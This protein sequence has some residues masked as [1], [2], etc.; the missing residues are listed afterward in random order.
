MSAIHTSAAEMIIMMRRYVYDM[1]DLTYDAL[2]VRPKALGHHGSESGSTCGNMQCLYSRSVWQGPGLPRQADMSKAAA[3]NC[4]A[5][6]RLY[7]PAFAAKLS[8][9]LH[10]S[11]ACEDP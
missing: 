5:I 2:G 8:H 3:C 7:H 1:F 9:H 11:F 6:M 10:F 4:G